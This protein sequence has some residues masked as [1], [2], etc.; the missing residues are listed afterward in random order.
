MVID[1]AYRDFYLF[2]LF[3]SNHPIIAFFKL[4]FFINLLLI[5]YT[6]RPTYE[7]SINY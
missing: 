4:L 6:I 2:F 7:Q 1:E 5:L 3:P